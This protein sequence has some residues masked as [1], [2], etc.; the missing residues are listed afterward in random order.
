MAFSH[1]ITLTISIDGKTLYITDA[2]GVYNVTTN[3]TGY[4]TPNP[5]RNTLALIPFVTYKKI[6]GD[7]N[8]VVNSYV[9]ESATGF[10]VPLGDDGWYTV[11]TYLVPLYNVLTTYLEDD[12]T[13]DTALNRLQIFK[14]SVWEDA[15]EADLLADNTINNS[16][17][18]HA[19]IAGI[20]VEINNVWIKGMEKKPCDR[21]PFT[22]K[23]AYLD[24]QLHSFLYDFC[25]GNRYEAQKTMEE[26]INYIDNC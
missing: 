19:K 11:N 10:T 1:K 9:A 5:E 15:T 14:S 7:V 2:T 25:S 20:S 16:L 18:N 8:V 22:E 21:T 12:I 4:G 17:Q 3:P 26:L 13:Y 6:S 23:T 24:F